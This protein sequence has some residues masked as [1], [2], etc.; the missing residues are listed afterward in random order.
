MGAPPTPDQFWRRA[1]RQG[2]HRRRRRGDARTHR[3]PSRVVPPSSRQTEKRSFPSQHRASPHALT[4]GYERKSAAGRIADAPTRSA[5]DLNGRH[6][7]L[8]CQIHEATPEVAHIDHQQPSPLRVPGQA[9][10]VRPC[11][12][13]RAHCPWQCGRRRRAVRAE[14]VTV[15]EPAR[16]C[17]GWSARPI[18]VSIGSSSDWGG[19]TSPVTRAWR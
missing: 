8:V 18:T 4:R 9:V 7:L 11:A 16:L 14:G 10:R 3:G 19:I 6:H 17:A 2:R 1:R 13:H 5:G 12:H 15:I